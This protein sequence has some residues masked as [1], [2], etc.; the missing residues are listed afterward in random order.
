M[1]WARE[2]LL[3][4][5]EYYMLLKGATRRGTD[6]FGYAIITRNGEIH[7]EKFLET[8]ES[9]IQIAIDDIENKMELDDI[10][11]ISCRACPETEKQTEFDMLQ[12]IVV[13]E[14]IVL[15]HNGGVTDSLR[16]TMKGYQFQT[17]IDSEMI[18]AAYKMHGNNMRKAM[19]F[20]SGSFAFVM[21]DKS[22]NKLYAVTSFNPLAHMYVKGYGYF[23]HSENS[24]LGAL[25]KRLTGSDTDGMNV[26]ESWYHHYL[27]GYTII[28]TDL[29]SGTQHQQKFKP[30]FLHPKWNSLSK[31]N[32]EKTIVVASGGIDSGLTA[33]ILNKVGRDVLCMH[34]NYGQKS[35]EAEFWAIQHLSDDFGIPYLVIS[36]EELYHLMVDPSMLLSNSIGITSGGEDIKST[37]AWVSGRNA[38]FATI[39][40]A[41]AEST[42]LNWDYRRV[43]IAAGWSQ[44]S[45]E[46]GGYPDNSF[47]FQSALNALKQ[48]G[49]ITGN[50]IK[51]LPV[52]QNI[53]KTEC[54]I[55]GDAIGFPFQYT[56]S[57]DNPEM[58]GLE[59]GNIPPH[60]YLCP[61]CGSTKL[62]ILA[63]DRANVADKRM[64]TTERKK[65]SE[66]TSFAS[67]LTIIDRLILTKHEKK[68]LKELADIS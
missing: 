48:Y 56:V 49:Y 8:N 17:E 44:L 25:C 37:I 22:K 42:I 28:E 19:E 60:P 41:F 27:P 6:G 46:T 61:D 64:F 29:D 43:S 15:S 54:W 68:K 5:Q 32:K 33:Y 3:D 47:Y 52:L 20:L 24:V 31:T 10:L 66:P 23:Y 51:F 45:E 26:W 53:T 65:L 34:F 55:L 1:Y 7:L 35:A 18:I 40:M 36:L 9:M 11:I 30:R 63:A 50:R 38:I 67:C 57:C 4:D 14:N 2:A 16:R 13:D 39:A 12:P 58:R 59:Y 21:M 62:S